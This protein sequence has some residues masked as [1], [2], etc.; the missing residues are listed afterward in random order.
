MQGKARI[1][2]Q[3]IVATRGQAGAAP[4]RRCLPCSA[5]C[6]L[7]SRAGPHR[8]PRRFAG[9]RV[10]SRATAASAAEHKERGGARDAAITHRM[11]GDLIRAWVTELDPLV[12]RVTALAAN[13]IRDA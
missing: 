5:H 12:Q 3:P 2:A 8:L 6:Y 11:N 13:H 10:P 4:R 9:R 1:H 7:N